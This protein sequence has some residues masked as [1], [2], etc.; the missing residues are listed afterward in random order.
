MKSF[1]SGKAMPFISFIGIMSAVILLTS[2][3]RSAVMNEATEVD[4]LK[5]LKDYYKDFFPIGVAVAP[6][7]LVGA[8]GELIK[9][10]FNS[11]TAENV[12]KP[13]PIHPEEN[14]YSWDDADRIVEFARANKM[15]VRGHTLCWHSQTGPWMFKD[16]QGNQVTKE[17]ALARLKEHISQV[18]SRY[19]GKVYAW[20]VVNEAI[21]DDNDPAKVYRQSPWFKICGEE[22]IAKAFRF[23][24][25]ADPDAVLFYNDY[26]TE[27]PVKREKIYNMVKKMLAEG[28]PVHGVG[29]QG[30]WNTNNPSEENIRKSIDQFSSLGIKVQVTELDVTIYTSRND[31][32]GMGFTS[33]R[34]QKQSDFYKMAFRVFREKKAEI[35][36]VTFWNISDARSWKD[37]PNMKV[38]PLLFDEK[39]KPKKAY[40]EVVKF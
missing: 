24:H 34:E 33:E 25:E 5:G 26:N 18:V 1:F 16:A 11:I 37:R 40:W 10:H 20:D 6:N 36:G 8:Q 14:R 29:L 15:K 23:A 4:S 28:V 7:S 17:V 31:T 19:K 9:K 22:Y 27:N 32:V 12:M 35:T 30:H 21:V 2:G 13:G 3:G 39:L 38:Y